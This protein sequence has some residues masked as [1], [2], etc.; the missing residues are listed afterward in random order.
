MGAGAGC[1]VL[2]WPAGVSLH[3]VS[4][5]E[6]RQVVCIVTLSGIERPRELEPDECDVL[7][8]HHWSESETHREVFP[9]NFTAL[10]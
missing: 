1:A 3:R 2:Q 6:R 9:L 5:G 10:P 7:R 8:V 4:L